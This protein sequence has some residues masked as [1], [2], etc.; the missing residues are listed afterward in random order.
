[1]LKSVSKISI[2]I[3]FLAGVS[4]D[5]TSII[6]DEFD[7]KFKSKN[8]NAILERICPMRVD[9][10]SPAI[11]EWENASDHARRQMT[12][13]K[14]IGEGSYGKVF[15]VDNSW[16]VKVMT[17]DDMELR[18]FAMTEINI[19]IKIK[20]SKLD[21]LTPVVDCCVNIRS[22]P[23]HE[24]YDTYTF[25]IAMPLYKQ[26][27]LQGF[28]KDPANRHI[29]GTADWKW[30]VIYG[31]FNGLKD[32]HSAH[33][34]HRDLKPANILMDSAYKIK[35]SDFGF[36][37]KIRNTAITHLGT[38]A[39]MAPE[40]YAGNGYDSRVDIYSAGLIMFQVLNVLGFTKSHPSIK[41]VQEYCKKTSHASY[42]VEKLEWENYCSSG[43]WE[44]VWDMLNNDPNN[45]PTAERVLE[46]ITSFPQE[47]FDREKRA[48]KFSQ[49]MSALAIGNSESEY[50][51]KFWKNDDAVGLIRR[52]TYVPTITHTKTNTYQNTPKFNFA[53]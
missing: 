52:N 6:S 32:L 19:G 20:E 10:C 27:T 16:A 12:N 44:L 46:R 43:L 23:Y 25:F 8:Y 3:I 36:T 37:R 15:A 7:A 41:D 31:L 2:L 45:R 47:F 9:Y 42:T 1:M 30:S 34:S 29:V 39:Y 5:I 26:G 18:K 17:V 33:Y 50:G 48:L 24:K 4:C 38:P 53:V 21:Y 49:E 51:L 40:I 13:V 11:K 22:D 28:M 14:K 35:I